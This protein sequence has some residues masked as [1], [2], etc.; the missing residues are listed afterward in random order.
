MHHAIAVLVALLHPAGFN[1]D[2][3]EMFAD[4]EYRHI[5]G[6]YRDELFRYR[7]FVPGAASP[8]NKMPLI[9]WLHG[10]G[11]AGD[12][13]LGQ[14]RW[15]EQ[16]VFDHPWKRQR[17]PFF[18][19]A[20]QCPL[21]NA[22]WTCGEESTGRDDMIDVAKAILDR[23]LREHPI[24]AD[25]VYLAGLSSGG[26]GCWELAIRHPTTFAAVAPIS[27]AGSRSAELD[28][29]RGVPVWAFNCSRDA[30]TPIERTSHTIESLR[31]AGGVI[32]LTEVD[33]KS[34][35]AWTSAFE[36]YHL[37]DWL[38]SQRRGQPSPAPGT[39][40]LTTRLHDFSKGWQWWQA[41]LQVAIPGLFLMAAWKA[42]RRRKRNLKPSLA[43]NVAPSEN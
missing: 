35:D 7:L 42:I 14:L 10:K 30:S 3:T 21:D 33:S 40:P 12:E 5:G 19:L 31:G 25:R 1:R 22:T 39:I 28:K 8:R 34:H 15:L 24:D 23:T 17:Y 41:L 11:E 20:V 18:L 2:F 43:L 32:H 37:L 13:N 4:L 9:V 27:S 29:L 26:A 16:T 36:D 6:V 38:L